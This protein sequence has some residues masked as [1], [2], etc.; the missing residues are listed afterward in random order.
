M[1]IFPVGVSFNDRITDGSTQVTLAPVSIN[2]RIETTDGIS[3]LAKINAER[4]SRLTP[5][6]ASNIGP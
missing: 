4:R 6:D 2:A 1:R 5:M 3:D